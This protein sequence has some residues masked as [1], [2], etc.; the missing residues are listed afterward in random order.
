M[1]AAGDTPRA[2]V[3]HQIAH[4]P[5]VDWLG[6][7]FI[8]VDEEHIRVRMPVRDEMRNGFGIVHGG[9]PYLLADTA[10]AFSGT[11]LG[12][13]MVTHHANTTYTAPARGAFLEAEARIHHR[14]G[15]YVICN[16]DV[17]DEDGT[18]VVHTSAH[19]VVSKRIAT[20]DNL[21]VTRNPQ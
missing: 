14:Y 2:R 18:P 17:F 1:S 10:F 3:D 8:E 5:T 7:E 15:R 4:D 21:T 12:E 19:G 13:P 20:T 6:I 11:A 9:F 16:V